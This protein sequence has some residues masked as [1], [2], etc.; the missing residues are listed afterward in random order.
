MESNAHPSNRK[1]AALAE[2][3]RRWWFAGLLTLIVL[4]LYSSSLRFG[5]I[6]DDPR[7]YQQGAGQTPWQIM[8]SLQT[9]QFYRP[10]AILLNRQLVSSQGVVHAMLAHALQIGAH[11]LVTLMSIPVLMALGLDRW[12][13]RLA[14]LVT[15]IHPFSYQAV[16]WQAPQQPLAMMFVLA[17]ILAASRS[18]ERGNPWLLGL[19]LV[20]YT[21]GLLFQESALPFMFAFFWLAGREWRTGRSLKSCF[22]VLPYLGIGIAYGLIWALAPRHGGITGR[23]FQPLVLGYLLQGVVFPVAWLLARGSAAWS[24]NALIALFVAVWLLLVFILWRG[25]QKRT[26]L[27]ACFWIA[28]GILPVWAGLRWEYVQIGSRLLYPATVGIAVLWAGWMTWAFE[29]VRNRVYRVGGWLALVVVVVVSFQQWYGFEKLY[30]LSTEHLAQAIAAASAQPQEKLVFINYPDR[31]EIE[32]RLYPLGF[33]G[34]TLAPVIQNLADY[35][36]ATTGQSARTLSLSSH[37]T[38]YEARQGYPYRVD[39]R[40]EDTKAEKL[41][42]SVRGASAIYLT[43]YA[44]D[45]TLALR[46]IGAIVSDDVIAASVTFGDR[47]QLLSQQVRYSAGP[48]HLLWLGLTWR[49]VGKA[50]PGDTAFV[51]LLTSDGRWVMGADGDP[52][53]GILPFAS[54][55]RGWTV[56]DEREMVLAGLSPGEYHIT[57]GV[58]NRDTGKRYLPLYPGKTQLS[59]QE[60]EIGTIAIPAN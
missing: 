5:L 55:E 1:M 39:L 22:W 40:G 3:G 20:S 19:S 45:G 12:P 2:Y 52:V 31:F 50:E 46:E 32:P 30:R 59:D 15:A 56:R 51:H 13:A 6:W 28:A 17:A 49:L 26:A 16:A 18:R 41:F 4:A 44:H 25:G 58:Y 29:P 10:L 23:G 57:V 11:L 38:G 35:A 9:Y 47:V 14:A 54:W 48:E 7:W 27:L 53:G 24:V 8:T 36:L 42:E 33:W 43:D 37:A 60:V 21:V 34:L